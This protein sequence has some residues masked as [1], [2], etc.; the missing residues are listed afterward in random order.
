MSSV[1]TLAA[2]IFANESG[3]RLLHILLTL[4]DRGFRGLY[5]KCAR[6]L[7]GTYY[8][9][10]LGRV[11]AWSNEVILEDITFVR[12]SCPD[13]EETFETCFMQYVGDRFRGRKRPTARVPSLVD[14]VRRFLESLAQHETLVTGDYFAKRDTLLKRV[15]CMDACRQSLYAL[16]TAENVRVELLSEVGAP[17]APE[18]EITPDDSVSQVASRAADPPV[19]RAPSV[20]QQEAAPPPVQRAPSVVQQEPQRAPS[21]VQ[22]E[23]QRAPSVARPASVILEPPKAPSAVQAPPSPP[24][25]DDY[26]SVVSRHDF[27]PVEH[28]DAHPPAL[29]PPAPAGFSSARSNVSIG[30]KQNRSPR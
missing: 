25:D 24:P 13:F 8:Q 23:P 16:V 18:P 15:A 22:Q 5:D 2:G 26:R 28:E 12:K 11:H 3:Q 9:Q 6:N 20:V 21:V 10:G 29:P 7:E 14:F 1:S 17:A 19:P 30:M 27:V 4:G